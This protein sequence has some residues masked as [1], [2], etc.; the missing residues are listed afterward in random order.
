MKE[1]NKS[2]NNN[3]ISKPPEPPKPPQDRIIMEHK[4]P[5]THKIPVNRN[6][7]EL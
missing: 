6:T 4:E 2:E 3:K 5:K 1:K 7:T